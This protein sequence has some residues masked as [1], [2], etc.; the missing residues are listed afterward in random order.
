MQPI[1]TLARVGQ[2][3]DLW[4]MRAISPHEPRNVVRIDRDSTLGEDA[5]E[6]CASCT[7]LKRPPGS[8][9]EIIDAPP[10]ASRFRHG[11]KSAAHVIT[12]QIQ[13]VIQIEH[14]TA[15]SLHIPTCRA[16]T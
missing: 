2:Q 15:G 7:L 5:V 3:V 6:Y 10:L 11:G 12:F 8:I 13:R 1:Q 9:E 16:S 4:N 14:D